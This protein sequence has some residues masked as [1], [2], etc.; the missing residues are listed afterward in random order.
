M[1][2]DPGHSFDR[3]V[4]SFN[5]KKLRH[6]QPVPPSSCGLIEASRRCGSTR[7]ISY[8]SQAG[9]HCRLGPALPLAQF[10]PPSPPT[11]TPPNSRPPRP[12]LGT[13]MWH[14]GPM[15]SLRC[16]GALGSS[17][18]ARGGPAAPLRAPPGLAQASKGWAARGAQRQKPRLWQPSPLSNV[19]IRGLFE[20]PGL[21]GRLGEIAHGVPRLS[22]CLLGPSL[23][24]L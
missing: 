5:R 7:Q 24:R 14:H 17:G 3:F 15:V 11:P 16:R 10:E 23:L 18:A 2:H 13:G 12:E 1:D 20:P 9:E 4:D 21:G 6:H 22:G 8:G 19:A